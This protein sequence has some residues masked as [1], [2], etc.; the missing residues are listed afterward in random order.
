VF[1]HALQW[2]IEAHLAAVL[3]D[4]AVIASTAPMFDGVF[5][6]VKG[7]KEVLLPKVRLRCKLDRTVLL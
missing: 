2:K 3:K 4:G 7:L 1:S 6:G 5:D